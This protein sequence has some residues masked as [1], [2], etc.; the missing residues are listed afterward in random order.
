MKNLRN[1]FLALTLTLALAALPGVALAGTAHLQIIH[2][3]ADPAAASVDIWVNGDRLLDDFAFRAATP[4]VEVPADVQLDVGVAPGD[5]DSPDDVIA[6]FPVTLASGGSYVAVANGVLDVAGF[7]PNP[8]G[9]STGFTIFAADRAPTRSWWGTVALRAMHGAT[10]APAVDI[11]VRK[12]GWSST[13]YGNVA[14]G[15][16][17]ARKVV[18]A[19][20]YLIDV[21]LPGQPGAVV[22]TY[23]ADLTG[24]ARGAAFV[25]ASGF[26][27]PAANQGGPAFGLFAALPDGRVL[28]L[29]ADEATARLQIIHNAADPAAAAVDIYV[30]GDRLLDDFA[31]RTA[32]PFIDVPAGV[33][34]VVGVAPGT[35]TSADDVIAQFPLTLADGETYVAMATGVLDPGAFADNP[36][37]RSIGFTVQPY[38]GARERGFWSLLNLNAFHGATDAP[39]VDIRYRSPWSHHSRA[40]FEDLGYGE[41]SGYRYVLGR[42]LILD[43]TPAGDAGTVVASFKA[44]LRGLRGGAAVVFASGFL[45]PGANQ[46]GAAFGLLA[47]LPDGRVIALPAAEKID[48]LAEKDGAVPS[49]A[50]LDQN[51]PNPFNPATT[52]AFS[53]PAESRVRLQVFDVRGRMVS[54]VLNEVRAAGRHEVMFDGTR[55]PSGLY[56][57]RI[58]AGDFQQVRQMTLV[59]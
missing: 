27:D 59:K 42:Q 56:F 40:L 45:N 2:N 8:D 18:L 29:P 3:A 48:L 57:Y 16:I 10:D 15:D 54:D 11:R 13:L 30:N 35:S 43:V 1:A 58:D 38:V 36:E 25:F 7:A 9:R 32:T 41:F 24:L 39:S 53:L 28:A 37:S 47:A 23:K 52:I 12:G 55:L 22:A 5:S 33:E 50:T 21:T 17:G 26:L 6:T 44:D 31:F 20:D 51:Y 46:D 34:L 14:Y 4:F 19:T 49:V